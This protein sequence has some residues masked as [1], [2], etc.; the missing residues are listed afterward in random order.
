MGLNFKEKKRNRQVTADGVSKNADIS[1]SWVGT[2]G[3]LTQKILYRRQRV[4]GCRL[5]ETVGAPYAVVCESQQTRTG[6][7]G[8]R[9]LSAV[10]MGERV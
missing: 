2:S 3:P 4:F 6:A 8:R 7:I 9:G 10:V 1:R 5:V